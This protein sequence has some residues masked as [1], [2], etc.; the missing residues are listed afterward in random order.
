MTLMPKLGRKCV[1]DGLDHERGRLRREME[2]GGV[3]TMRGSYFHVPFLSLNGAERADEGTLS[4][5]G[6]VYLE[7]LLIGRV[8][9]T[10]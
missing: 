10:P 4:S 9:R 5:Y 1:V 3:M 7:P 6:I 2:K 8:N